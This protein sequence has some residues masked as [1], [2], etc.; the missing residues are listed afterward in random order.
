MIGVFPNEHTYLINFIPRKNFKIIKDIKDVRGIKF[1]SL[2]M[3]PGWYNYNTEKLE[4]AFD[5]IK[6]H[7]PE[8]IK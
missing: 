6:I 3:M 8:L 2:I 1:T 5:Y 7:Q 4:D